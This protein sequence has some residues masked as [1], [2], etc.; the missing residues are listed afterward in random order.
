MATAAAAVAAAAETSAGA[1]ENRS[2][3]QQ[4]QQQHQQKQ[5]DATW[6]DDILAA[7]KHQI[8]GPVRAAAWPNRNR[9]SVKSLPLLLIY[10]AD[11]GRGHS[12][13]LP[14]VSCHPH[15]QW[16]A[17]TVLL[18]KRGLARLLHLM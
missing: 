15:I 16:Q 7:K 6:S 11:Q 4:G 1:K 14:K 5:E 17:T 3:I 9:S 2:A 12:L 13:N 10:L 18:P 8:K